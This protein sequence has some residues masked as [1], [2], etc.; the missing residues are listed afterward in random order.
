MPSCPLPP[1]VKIMTALAREI[2]QSFDPKFR[3]VLSMGPSVGKKL[4]LYVAL[5]TLLT[6]AAVGFVSYQILDSRITETFR[7]NTLDSSTLLASR[8]RNEL[9][10]VAEKARLLSAAALEEFKNADDQIRFLEDNLAIDD[11]FIAMSLF[12]RSPASNNQW[13]LVFR[14]TRPDGDPDAINPAQFNDLELKFPLDFAVVNTGAIDVNVGALENGT[15]ILRLLVPIVRKKGGGFAQVIAIEVRQERLT[16]AFSEANAQFS[17]LLSRKGRLLSQTDPT[18]FTYGEDL[19]HLP[20]YKFATAAE[21]DNGNLDFHEIPGAPLQIGS[22]HKVG[23]GDLVVVSQ[24]SK[25]HV[26]EVLRDYTRRAGIFS[27]CAMALFSIL[28][29][30]AVWVTVGGRLDATLRALRKVIQGNYLVQLPEVGATDEIGAFSR[31]LQVLVDDLRRKSVHFGTTA[32]LKDRR[33]RARLDDGKLVLSG[34]RG[35]A[36]VVDVRV[37]GLPVLSA[38]ADPQDLLTELNGFYQACAD[39]VAAARGIL[40][41]VGGTGFRA[42]WGF[43]LSSKQDGER[44]LAACLRLRACFDLLNK[45]LAAK[46]LP[47]LKLSVGVHYG[48]VAG[49][50]IGT[51][52]RKEFTILGEA[53][54]TARMVHQHTEEYGT[55][56]LL[57]SQAVSQAPNWYQTERAADGDSEKIALFELMGTGPHL[58]KSSE[59]PDLEENSS[60]A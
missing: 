28:G 33:F 48:S 18:H 16:A 43:P 40:D 51:D 8:V 29:L 7:K 4:S 39:E 58:V 5:S 9:R 50:E 34:D 2:P 35:K 49:G 54:E 46:N 23:F 6:A 26:M 22:F 14:L 42:F 59:D 11:Q 30:F 25:L 32:K 20:V 1:A 38:Q 47:E 60:A 45:R 53:V 21:A 55:D 52:S 41:D 36:F 27:I 13:K 3:I 44:T 31:E 10:H 15:P 56:I 17:Y 24:A 57:T 19:S 12:R 37:L